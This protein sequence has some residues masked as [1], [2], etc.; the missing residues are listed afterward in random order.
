M[1]EFLDKV[2]SNRR[3]FVKRL[4]G[5]GFAAPAISSFLMGAAAVEFMAPSALAVG[6]ATT[7]ATSTIAVSTT[8]GQAVPE[9]DPGSAA[10]ALTVV[11]GAVLIVRDRLSSKDESEPEKRDIPPAD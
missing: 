10:T 5:A 1:N 11:A 4:L 7:A 9:I 3:S 2:T 8:L 6:N